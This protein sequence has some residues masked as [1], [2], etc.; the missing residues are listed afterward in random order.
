VL[1]NI[2]N[3]ISALFLVLY[4]SVGKM[5]MNV[6]YCYITLPIA[7]KYFI[8]KLFSIFYQSANVTFYKLIMKIALTHI[9][10]K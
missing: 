9:R 8:N 5:E 7:K 4:I 3:Y 2:L 1:K 10:P 6:T